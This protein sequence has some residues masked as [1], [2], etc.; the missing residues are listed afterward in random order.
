MLLYNIIK[1]KNNADNF[2]ENTQV[3]KFWAFA[4]QKAPT[5]VIKIKILYSNYISWRKS[6]ETI[7]LTYFFNGNHFSFIS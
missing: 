4:S 3:T 1:K 2:I 6:L 7:F 5:Y